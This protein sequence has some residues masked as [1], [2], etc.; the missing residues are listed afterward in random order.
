MIKRY[1]LLPDFH[2]PHINKGAV[3]AVFEFI[4]YFKPDAV[5]ILGDA[6]NMDS[7]NHWE[8]SK[9]NK[10]YFEKKRLLEEYSSFDRD[11]LTPLEKL[12]GKNCEKTFMGGNHEFWVD[13][14]TD[15]FPMLLGIVELEVALKLKERG[16]EWIPWI[17]YDEEKGSYKRGI[18]HYGKLLAFHGQYINK[19]HAHKTADS[20]SK[21]CVYGHC[22]DDE[23]ELLTKR[24]WLKY[25]DIEP[26]KDECLTMNK[27]TELLEWNKINK[28]YVYDFDG[29][30]IKIKSTGID[31]LVDGDHGLVIKK[32]K[33]NGFKYIKANELLN[34]IGDSIFK[35]AGILP[36]D[37]EFDMS[38]DLLKLLAWTQSEGDI[39]YIGNTPYVNITQSNT[40][41]IKEITELLDKLKISYLFSEKDK[42]PYSTI[43]PYRFRI[44]VDGS[45]LI[46]KY[47][48][49]KKIVPDWFWELSN[50]QF[51]L[52]VSEYIKGDGTTYTN[53]YH[54]TRLLYCNNNDW[55]NAFQ[56]RLFECGY[57][58][59]VYWRKGS[60]KNNGLCAQMSIIKKEYHEIRNKKHIGL[61]KY[62]GEMWCVNVDNGTLVVK[63]NDKITITQNT[64][65]LQLYT[66]ISE[67]DAKDYHTAQSIG[68]LCN[69]SPEFLK[70]RMNRWVNA[71]GVLYLR[72]DGMYNLYVP[73]II[74]GQFMFEGKMFG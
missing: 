74:N 4:E 40:K 35:V 8:M 11:I 68:C 28:K 72:D 25:T 52:Y 57:K 56:I 70:G 60:F 21:S 66:K 69:T 61:K 42:S 30:M 15:K 36:Q 58:T 29:E 22:F 31:L 55:V 49:D 37:K 53:K 23:T 9:G 41:E 64:H 33:G 17:T 73:V 38:D 43:Q 45:K 47:I 46:T 71:F 2:H 24:G 26:E 63:R 7:I 10:K 50:R 19:Y 14:L 54:N 18:K 32:V 51:E 12:V 27:E 20:Y 44:R 48:P 34:T 59:R 13:G 39:S 3:D 1:V 5:N 6:M 67:D 65:D 16:W 62:K